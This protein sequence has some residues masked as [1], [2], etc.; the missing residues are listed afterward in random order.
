MIFSGFGH[1]GEDEEFN[2]FAEFVDETVIGPSSSRTSVPT[3]LEHGEV[4]LS[5]G[6]EALLIFSMRKVIKIYHPMSNV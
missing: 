1:S 6:R 5:S 3:P 4:D 2:V